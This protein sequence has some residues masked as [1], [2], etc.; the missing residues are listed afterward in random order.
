MA[1][2]ARKIYV[3][4]RTGIALLTH[5]YGGKKQIGSR[6]PHHFNSSG[7]VIR[8]ALQQLEKLKVVKKD[9]KN[10]ELKMNS[11]I[12][13]KEGFKDLNRIATEVAIA[14]KGKDLPY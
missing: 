5:I 6:R 3:R 13:S 9:R 11:R 4:P 8:W 14:Q 2:L 10:D 1:S 12:I 7:K